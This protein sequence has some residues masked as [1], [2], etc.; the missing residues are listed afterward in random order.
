M[1]PA[2]RIVPSLPCL[3]ETLMA[4]PPDDAAL[5]L[6]EWVTVVERFASGLVAWC[7][8][9]VAARCFPDTLADGELEPPLS[10]EIRK[11]TPSATTARAT[12]AAARPVRGC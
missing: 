10:C 5:A 12:I 4:L 6:V 3:V 2:A 11:I 8:A 7:L 9:T 1:G